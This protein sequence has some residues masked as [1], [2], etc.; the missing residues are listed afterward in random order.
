MTF[1]VISLIALIGFAVGKGRSDVVWTVCGYL[2]A[3]FAIIMVILTGCCV[4]YTKFVHNIW[5]SG[6]S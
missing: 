4:A 1:F 3:A 5:I 6:M 2:L